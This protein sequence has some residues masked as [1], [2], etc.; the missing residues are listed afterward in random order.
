M[1][2]GQTDGRT[3]RLMQILTLTDDRHGSIKSK[4]TFVA[5]TPKSV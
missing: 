5:S 1:T 4:A 3:D 2:N